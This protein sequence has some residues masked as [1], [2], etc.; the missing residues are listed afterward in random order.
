MTLI[1]NYYISWERDFSW[2]K[3]SKAGDESS[4]KLCFTASSPQVSS[5]QKQGEKKTLITCCETKLGHC[6]VYKRI[7]V[8]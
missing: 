4:R 6:K 7:R 1:G 8:C 5:S 2:V 3:K